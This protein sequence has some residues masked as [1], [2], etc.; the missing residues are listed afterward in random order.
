M[1]CYCNVPANHSEVKQGKNEGKWFY[2][3]GRYG[4]G[5][6]T[7]RFFKWAPNPNSDSPKLKRRNAVVMKRARSR[8]LT[9]DLPPTQPVSEAEELPRKKRSITKDEAEMIDRLL[10]EAETKRVVVENE[11]KV[12]AHM[13][14][15]A[16]ADLF[17]AVSRNEVFALEMTES[18][19][20]Q[21][22]IDK[23]KE[24]TELDAKIFML[25]QRRKFP[26]E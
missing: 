25:Q 14:R 21:C 17:R 26:I 5:Q 10:D 16:T 23:T 22:V 11:L 6:D 3:C 4:S 18:L 12:Y 24:R 19:V 13:L 9:P 20:R 7:C 2:G 1:E 8:S 15:D